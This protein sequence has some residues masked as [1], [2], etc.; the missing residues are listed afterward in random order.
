MP[1]EANFFRIRVIL[2][3][4]VLLSIKSSAYTA[5]Y[6][7][8][9]DYLLVKYLDGNIKKEKDGVFERNPQGVPVQPDY[10]G[11]NERYFRS[12]VESD[13]PHFYV[14]PAPAEK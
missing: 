3:A 6:H 13:G 8:L 14:G 4:K 5:D 2:T 12:I 11:Y 7:K 9:G 10:G 1:I